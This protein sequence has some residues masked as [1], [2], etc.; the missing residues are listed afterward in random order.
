[1]PTVA[2][3]CQIRSTNDP[4]RNLAIS[5]SVIRDAVAAG[6]TVRLSLPF[7]SFSSSVPFTS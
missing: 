5:A 7:L 2:A 4:V 1:M 3:I 6:A